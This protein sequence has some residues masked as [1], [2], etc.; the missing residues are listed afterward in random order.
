[1]TETRAVVFDLWDTLALWPAERTRELFARL[2]E[3]LGDVDWHESYV[4]RMT[5]PLERYF[6]SLGADAALAAELAATRTASTREGLEPCEGAVET[7]DELRRR[8]LRLGLIS[9]CSEDVCLVFPETP[10]AGRFDATVFSA[11]C[12]LMKPDPEIYRL[13]CRRLG[14]SP[15]EC[16]YVGDGAN[17]ELAGAAAVGM[18]PVL[19]EREG[20]ERDW[21]GPRI[22]SIPEV[23]DL[24]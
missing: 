11:D 23:L 2:S 4:E 17:D 15:D 24:V 3:R 7:L 19:I 12:G 6:A 8:G 22:T 18:R 21:S 5:M 1:V 20:R 13:A 9:V 14:V 10:F 16:L